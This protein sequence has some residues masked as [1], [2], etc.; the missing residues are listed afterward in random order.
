L[1]GDRPLQTTVGH[2]LD[3]LSERSAALRSVNVIR[4]EADGRLVGDIVD[5]EGFLNAARKHAS[6]PR[7]SRRW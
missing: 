6:I 5:G 3:S 2:R 4:R 7:T 1:R